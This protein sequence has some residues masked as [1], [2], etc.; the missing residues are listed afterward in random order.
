MIKFIVEKPNLSRDLQWGDIFDPFPTPTRSKETR[1]L[2]FLSGSFSLAMQGKKYWEEENKSVSKLL[3][4][5][6][7]EKHFEDNFWFTLTKPF[8]A[9]GSHWWTFFFT[10]RRPYWGKV[11][12]CRSGKYIEFACWSKW[13]PTPLAYLLS[14]DMTRLG[15]LW[16]FFVSARPLYYPRQGCWSLSV[17][18]RGAREKLKH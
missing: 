9:W 4:Y 16:S 11:H 13:L 14:I 8:S 17:A 15:R 10:T 12:Y 7:G 3:Q 6:L 18:D 5:D 2:K 1:V